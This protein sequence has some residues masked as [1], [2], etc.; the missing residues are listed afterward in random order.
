MSTGIIVDGPRSDCEQQFFIAHLQQE[1]WLKTGQDMQ[2]IWV[3]IFERVV[4]IRR[5]GKT[6][7]DD[8]KSVEIRGVRNIQNLEVSKGL[9]ELTTLY[10]LVYNDLKH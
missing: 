1:Y 3:P 4:V 8:L 6:I 9:I 5:G 7:V 2:L 10:K